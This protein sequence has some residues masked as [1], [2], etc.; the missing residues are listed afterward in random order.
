M[1]GGKEYDFNMETNENKKKLP[2]KMRLTLGVVVGAYLLYLA[3]G[4]FENLGSHA[5]GEKLLFGAFAC[6]FAIAGAVLTAYA[7]RALMKGEY[8]KG[9]AEE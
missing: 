7:A 1:R 8:D 9:E 4:L 2:S 6:V 5:G 3:Y